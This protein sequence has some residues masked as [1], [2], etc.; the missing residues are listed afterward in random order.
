MKVK[1]R[2]NK[3]GYS[4]K[5]SKKDNIKNLF[6]SL[7]FCLGILWCIFMGVYYY[8][9]KSNFLLD[10]FNAIVSDKF[11]EF[12][13]EHDDELREIALEFSKG[14]EGG[15]PL[16]YVNSIYNN[17]ENVSYIPTSKYRILYEPIYVLNTGGD[18]RNTAT[19]VVALINSIGFEANVDC[20][21]KEMH[22]VAV[23]PLITYGY[24]TYQE[25]AIVDLARH[26]IKI[27]HKDV[28]IWN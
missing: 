6:Y 27:I 15:F 19:L 21:L 12:A 20:D 5:Y 11:T 22:C 8:M 25:K 16:C 3:C 14:C 13:I 24:N 18:C 4:E 26:E 1:Y 7:F 23:I 10:D 17:L 28:D 2:C 9:N